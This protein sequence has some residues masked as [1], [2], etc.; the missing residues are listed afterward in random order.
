LWTP[1]RPPGVVGLEPEYWDAFV[2]ALE[3]PT[4]ELPELDRAIQAYRDRYG[5]TDY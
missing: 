1:E 5:D 4:R 2:A 3:R